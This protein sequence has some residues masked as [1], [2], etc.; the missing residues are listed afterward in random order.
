MLQIRIGTLVCGRGVID[1]VG[2]AL[3]QDEQF[4]FRQYG[5]AGNGHLY[6]CI[7]TIRSNRQGDDTISADRKRPVAYLTVQAGGQLYRGP[8][9]L[10]RLK[11]D[12][13][14]N[15]PQL[16]FLVDMIFIHSGL[17][18]RLSSHVLLSRSGLLAEHRSVLSR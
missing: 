6:L 11:V 2:Y 4:L 1:T 13:A 3:G 15:G 17:L 16:R 12:P 14:I 10:I 8:R 9:C 18:N 5:F 7:H